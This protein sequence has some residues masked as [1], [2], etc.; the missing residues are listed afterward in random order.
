[1]IS[2]RA[3]IAYDIRILRRGNRMLRLLIWRGYAAMTRLVFEGVLHSLVVQILLGEPS[4]SQ[5]FFDLGPAL[6]GLFWCLPYTVSF[7]CD[8]AVFRDLDVHCLRQLFA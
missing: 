7:I 5:H 3:L 4:L 6:L 8:S 2:S 1:M